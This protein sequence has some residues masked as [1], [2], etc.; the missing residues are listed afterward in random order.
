MLR[1]DSRLHT[2]RLRLSSSQSMRQKDPQSQ[3]YQF[4]CHSGRRVVNPRGQEVDKGRSFI[5][6]RLRILDFNL[7]L[8]EIYSEIHFKESTY[9][10]RIKRLTEIRI[11]STQGD[12]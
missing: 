7:I 10:R 9:C 6:N 4:A 5:Q 12:N 2:F 8:V 3:L 1:M 11:F